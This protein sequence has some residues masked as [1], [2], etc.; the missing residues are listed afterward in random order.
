MDTLK[1]WDFKCNWMIRFCRIWK[2]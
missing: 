2:I 1:Y